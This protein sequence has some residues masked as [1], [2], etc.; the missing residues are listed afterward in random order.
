MSSEA[1]TRRNASWIILASLI[2]MV[3]ALTVVTLGA[4][5]SAPMP[6]TMPDGATG[7]LSAAYALSLSD[8]GIVLTGIQSQGGWYLGMTGSTVTI[9]NSATSIQWSI[10]SD[11]N[12][13]CT[14]TVLIGSS[15]GTCICVG[16][17]G[18][19]AGF[20]GTTNCNGA[21][22]MTAAHWFIVDQ[23]PRESGYSVRFR[24]CTGSWYLT[25]NRNS[26]NNLLA[27]NVEPFA[28]STNYDWYLYNNDAF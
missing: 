14:G 1:R 23:M 4:G 28:I 19:T 20:I 8:D 11:D 9:G 6:P 21:T 5:Q 27:S 10:I 17:T 25:T 18:A 15:G 22:G 13:G 2:L 26:G 16:L 12:V 24:S 7:M 3:A